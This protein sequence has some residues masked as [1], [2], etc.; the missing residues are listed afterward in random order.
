MVIN[1]VC[2]NVN[3][4]Y[5]KSTQGKKDP[6]KTYYS[7]GLWFVDDNEAGEIPCNEEIFKVCKPISDEKN[8]QKKM[9]TIFNFETS[10]NTQWQTFQLTSVLNKVD[11]DKK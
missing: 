6:S 4:L 1:G 7:V 10:Y 9:A 2:N 11:A 5:V 3:V 8:I